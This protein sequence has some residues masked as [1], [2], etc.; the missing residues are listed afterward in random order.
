MDSDPTPG[1]PEEVR[2]LAE[3]LQEFADDVGEALGK[4]RGM[5]GDRAMQDWSGL[6]AD[7]FRS[8]FDGVPENL[9]KLRDS[10]DM[11]ADALARYWPELERAQAQADRALDRAISAQADLQAAWA[12]LGSAEDWVGRAGEEAERLQEEG[13]DPEPP[14]EADIRAAMRDHDA[15]E[16]AASAAQGRVDAAQANLNAARELAQQAEEMREEAARICAREI[17]AASDAGIQNRSWWQDAV[18]W[19]VDNWDTI[20]DIAKLVVAVLGVVVLIIGG[21]LAWVVLA[22]ALIVLADTLIK[23]ARGQASL[24]DVAM[25][26]LDCIPGMKGLTTLGGLAAGV[27]GLARTGLRGMGRGALGLG[28]RTR[29]DAIPMN[30]RNACGDPVDVATGELL[31]S[32]TDIELPGVL[33][34]VIERHH[35]SSYR[36]GQSFGRSWAST[37]DQRLVLDEYGARLFS[38]DGMTLLYPRPLPDEPVLPIEGP[39]WTL[40]WDGRPGAPLRVQQRETGRTLHFAVT[41]GRPGSELPL[42]AITDSNDNHI[43]IAYDANGTPTDIHHSGGYHIGVITESGRVTELRLLNAPGRPTLLTYGYDTAGLLSEVTNSSGRPLTFCYDDHAR[44]TRWEDRNG[45]WYTYDYDEHGR[46]VFT[47]GTDR[48]L[49]YRYAYAP[50]HH[51]TV[52]TDSLGQDAVHQF[53]DSFQMIARTDPLGHTITRTWDRYDRPLTTTDPLG[54]TTTHTWDEHGDLIEITSPDGSRQAAEYDADGRTVTLRQADGGLWRQTYDARGNRETLVDPAGNVTRFG[55]NSHGAVI[56]MTDALGR[57]KRFVC[58]A[59]GL[60]MSMTG[61]AGQRTEVVRDGFGR[62]TE[63]VDPLGATTRFTYTV[64]GRPLAEI[65]PSGTTRGWEWDAEGNCLSHRDENGATTRYTYGVFDQLTEQV[66]ADGAR[67]TFVRDTEL[68]LVAVVAPDERR[69]DYAW[70]PAGHLIRESD[71]DDRE[72]AYRFDAAGRLIE[73]VNALGQSVAYVRD[74]LGH[75]VAKQSQEGVTTFHYDLLGQ[76]LQAVSPD[77]R[78]EIQRDPLGRPLTQ[79]VNGRVLAFTYNDVGQPLAR[80]TPAGRTSR[81]IYDDDGQTAQMI[82]AGRSLEFERDALGRETERRFAD[83]FQLSQRWDVRGRLARQSLRGLGQ[84]L[85]ARA[86]SY[87]A[88]HALTVLEHSPGGATH[89]DLDV[90]GRPLTA[91]GPA[92]MIQEEYAYDL[93]GNQTTAI[94]PGNSSHHGSRQYSGTRLTSAGR[95]RYAYDAAGRVVTRRTTRLSKKPDIWHYRWDAE[96]RLVETVT[97][98]GDRWRYQY[99]PIGR[100]MAKLRLRGTDLVEET[101]FTW[102]DYTLVEQSTA[103]DG[104]AGTDTFAISWDYDG[105]HPLTQVDGYTQRE[106]DTRFFGIVTDLVGT[107]TELVDER[108]EIAWRGHTSLWGAQMNSQGDTLV[109]TPLRFPGQY[110]DPETGWHYNVHRHYDPGTGRYTSPDPLGLLPGPNHYGYVPDPRIWADPL[111]LSAHPARPDFVADQHGTVVPTDRA[112][113]EQGLQDAVNSGEPGFSTFPTRSAGQGYTLPSGETVRIMEPSGGATLRASFESANGQP[114]SPF[115][116]R[117]PQAPRGTRGAAARQYIRERTHV[118][119]S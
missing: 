43:H 104:A 102:S 13:E 116:G 99:D 84:E 61:P 19:V 17:E 63:L 41:P 100:R 91:R 35:I 118:E 36:D 97:P 52:V 46:C 50:E 6:S 93:L 74:S 68:R 114:V 94:W 34:L 86:Y 51:R 75:V 14:S 59:A 31:M 78:L 49:E 25:A 8:E 95:T 66:T 7:A 70:D 15:A 24:F 101:T 80:T 55:V 60:P 21:P 28:R 117:Q 108:G 85:G 26:A 3:D 81:W 40:V 44:M 115:T 12:E 30:G 103:A 111:G 11:A 64:E 83:V 82:S 109:D 29:G 16:A 77:A 47:T 48:A 65:S 73:R 76:L 27:R 90:I 22:A 107:P 20:V 79:T 56:S 110:S 39:R 88:D 72:I 42:I 9:T 112:R 38:A 58:N 4:I 98:H 1:E 119:L 32:A 57:S 62:I 106:I 45:Y 92:G 69:W 5:A 54:H 113:L 2:S 105:L 96:D 37:L 67:H 71:F 33:P 53:N 18:D 10:Y 89:W 87:R 23:Y